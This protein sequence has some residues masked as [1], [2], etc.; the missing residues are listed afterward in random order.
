[1]KIVGLTGGIACGKSTA[2]TLLR[3]HHSLPTV[4]ADAIARDLLAP[5][6]PAYTQV[7]A[8]FGAVSRTIIAGNPGR[9]FRR[10][11]R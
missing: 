10:F 2:S 6:T 8:E 9:V 7:V 1:M 3:D 5:G 4:D 11:Q